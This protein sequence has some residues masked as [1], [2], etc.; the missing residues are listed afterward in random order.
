MAV[1]IGDIEFAIKANTDALDKVAKS[2]QTVAKNV[3]K[4]AGKLDRAV[5][6][7]DK[8][9]KKAAT[10]ARGF[11]TA[12]TGLMT[13]QQR[14]QVKLKN[15]TTASRKLEKQYLI[16]KDR[17]LA[18][19][20]AGISTGN[21][22]GT[23]SASFKRINQNAVGTKAGFGA[24]EVQMAGFRKTIAGTE[25]HLAGM[26]LTN[27]KVGRQMADAGKKGEKFTKFIRDTQSASVLAVGP[28]SGLGARVQALGSIFTRTGSVA[29]GLALALGVGAATGL[30]VAFI[31]MTKEAITASLAM[32][33]INASLKIATGSTLEANESFQFVS[34]L[35]ERLGLNLRLAAEQ[36]GKIS[37]AARGT[38]LANGEL[39]NIFEGVSTAASA[40]NLS[41]DQTTG[42]FRALEQMISKGNVQAEELRG[43]LGERLPG[44]F[45]LAAKAMGV[46]TK[47]LNKMLEQGEVLA[48]DLLPK[49]ANELRGAFTQ[50]AL[51]NA[52][53]LSKEI[54]RLRTAFF[55]LSLE[56]NK[57]TRSGDIFAELIRKTT[58][59][60]KSATENM[61]LFT[62]AI[63]GLGTALGLLGLLGI[64]KA[65][66]ALV[67]WILKAPGPLKKIITIGSKVHPIL[68]LIA[69]AAGAAATAFHKLRDASDEAGDGIAPFADLE[70]QTH[71]FARMASLSDRNRENLKK[72]R[73]ETD[74]GAISIVKEMVAINKSIAARQESLELQ[75]RTP[76]M[77]PGI[78]VQE[79]MNF[80]AFRA[81]QLE[82]IRLLEIEHQAWALLQAAQS[83][84][85]GKPSE[86]PGEDPGTTEGRE[87]ALEVMR[88]LTEE[89]E[90]FVNLENLS[91]T[92]IMQEEGMRAQVRWVESL[93][94]A[95]EIIR[96][97]AKDE[98]G[99]FSSVFGGATGKE[100][101]KAVANTI[102]MKKAMEEVNEEQMDAPANLRE[103]RKMLEEVNQ[104]QE[105]FSLFPRAAAELNKE[106]ARN[107]AVREY[108]ELLEKIPEKLR[109]A[110]MSAEEFRKELEKLD[111]IKAD[112]KKTEDFIKDLTKAYDRAVEGFIEA[113]QKGED[114]SESFRN[115]MVA[116]LADIQRAILEAFVFDPIKVFIE[117]AIRSIIDGQKALNESSGGDG[118]FALVSGFFSG[119]FGNMFGGTPAGPQS[120][121]VNGPPKFTD[122]PG[123]AKGGITGPGLLINSRGVRAVGEAGPE[124]ILPLSRD[125]SGNLG[126]SGSGGGSNVTIIIDARGSNGDA[127]VEEAVVRGIQSATPFIIDGAVAKVRDSSRRSLG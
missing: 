31:K 116:L 11:K 99:G 103:L 77:D 40:L 89:K 36:F 61:E 18:L 29:K 82:K 42:I 109:A 10:S 7:I 102:D 20:R 86:E 51:R 68:T 23:L 33:K 83:R 22:L 37:A 25:R 76:G 124:A 54:E 87:K 6:K 74:K 15:Q 52:N 66:G 93:H 100:L 47:E 63:V 125:S 85:A 65:L 118:F 80:E 41:A 88:K 96:D 55:E 13:A 106:F 53:K 115:V 1:S 67:G 64:V 27:T 110:E 46:T 3:D 44:A 21:S 81:R 90:K 91:R 113:L 72:L 104:E 57:A 45:G 117:Q 38:S 79:R 17:L 92:Q 5:G 14:L 70:Q 24:A 112:F 49:L 48:E 95:R 9:F 34:D 59:L 94:E 108:Q 114:A 98:E 35:S 75:E 69:I 19:N 121:P 50:D 84:A 71:V 78:A 119:I 4:M 123:M 26:G 12:S 2:L 8:G 16:M 105:A 111:N 60:T 32:D 39:K 126:I 58:S 62:A 122:A 101:E 97:L 43:Q 107:E 73:E 120:G 28:L 56:F 127:A 30:V